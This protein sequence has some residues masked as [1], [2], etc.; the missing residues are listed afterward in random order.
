MSAGVSPAPLAPVLVLTGPTGSGKSDYALALAERFA[1][2]LISVDSA[3]VFRGMDIGTAKPSPEIQARH[4]HRLIDIRDP[5]ESYS[6]GEFVRDARAAIA[7]AH[8]AG[9]L[10]LLV[11]GTMLYLRALLHG[12]APLP[13]ASPAVRAELEA[14][15]AREGWS[16]L[17]AELTRVDPLTAARV[18]VRDP[19][20]IQRALEVYQLTGRAI[21]DWQ[22]GTRGA[23]QD[24]HWVRVALVPSDR[25]AHRARLATRFAAMIGAGLVEEVRQLHERADL[26]PHLPSIRS[27]GYRQLWEFLEG[28]AAL[29]QACA[30]AVEATC[31]LAK[32]QLTW[33]KTDTE[34]MRLDPAESC[35]AETLMNLTAELVA[36][37]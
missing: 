2:D 32:R 35:T 15:A 28:H 29:D 30:K 12:I 7:T 25:R 16:A 23:Q 3:Q 22:R 34:L 13:Q 20:R 6:A 1:V 4:P 31:Q 9:R 24:F 10:P 14:R 27:I 11:G 17:H 26:G 19:Q 18:H 21:S 8:V 37:R 36:S 33:L 5:L